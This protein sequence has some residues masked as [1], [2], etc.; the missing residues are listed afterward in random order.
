[1]SDSLVSR[2]LPLLGLA[3]VVHASAQMYAQTS[4]QPAPQ[5]AAA[6]S[7]VFVDEWKNGN[8]AD[9][10]A[11]AG[12]WTVRAHANSSASEQDGTLTLTAAA[13]K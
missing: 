5:P 6:D 4:A 9:S 12:F 13:V 1:M 3:V 8:V 10:D 2:L 7:S 11:H